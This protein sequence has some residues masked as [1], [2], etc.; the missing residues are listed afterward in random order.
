[1]V[2]LAGSLHCVGMCGPI[3]L[4]YSL[5]VD[6]AGQTLLSARVGI[7]H[8]LVFH[9]GRIL[10]YMVLGAVAGAVAHLVNLQAFMGHLRGIVSLVGGML[11][12][13]MGLV[14]LK[15]LP[16]PRWA[17]PSSGSVPWVTRWI[18]S[19]GL[20]GRM[21]LGVATGFLPCMLPWAMMVK[22]ATSSGMAE[23]LSI[24]ALF[25]LGTVPALF[26][27]GISAT[28]ISVRLRL[29]G[30]RIAS[31]AVIS[32]GAILLYKGGRA[33]LRLHGLLG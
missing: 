17:E 8:H 4:A 30:E 9:A 22:A 20:G 29:L 15:V 12:V 11:L 6:R 7:G 28:A 5:Q 25:G 32:M 31:I 26:L 19:R 2:G 27:L 18:R 14:L 13:L 21:A 23:A 24:M 3:V 1:M 33:L 10:S 16:L